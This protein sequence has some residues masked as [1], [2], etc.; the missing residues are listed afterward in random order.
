MAHGA[1]L[2]LPLQKEWMSSFYT[3]HLDRLGMPEEI[4]ELLPFLQHCDNGT[5]A[6]GDRAVT[7]LPPADSVFSW[8]GLILI[9]NCFPYEEGTKCRM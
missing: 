8:I 1:V 4:H 9:G 7:T 5:V 6:A 2:F 3:L